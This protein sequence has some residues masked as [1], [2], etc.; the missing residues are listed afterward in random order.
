MK[1]LLA[2]LLAVV[3]TLSL[4]SVMA[5]AEGAQPQ[6]VIDGVKDAAYSD[7]R[8]IDHSYWYTW[9]DASNTTDVVDPDRV[10]N[11][12]WFTWD[13][14]FVYLYFTA[15]G[16]YDLYKPAEGEKKPDRG[17]TFYEQINLY[18]DTAPSAEYLTPCTQGDKNEDGTPADCNHFCCN[19]NAGPGKYNRVMCRYSAA[20][21][22][23]H[24]YYRSD[25]GMFLTFEQFCERRGGESGYEDLEAMYMK[26]NGAGEV[27]GFID[28]ETN[29]YGFEM[30][31]PRNPEEE[32]FQFN[33]VNDVDGYEFEAEGPELPYSLSFCKAP[34]TNSAELLEI[35]F[36]DYEEED[37]PAPVKAII[38]MRSEL[39]ATVE[40]I[41]SEHK[42]AVY[43]LNHEFYQ[44]SDEHKAIALKQTELDGI[45]D[46]LQA[47]VD[48]VNTLAY[49]ANLGD[50]NKD[51]NINANDAL[52][53]LRAAV[54]KVDLDDD[55]IARADVTGDAAVNAKDALEML[56][57]TV[58]KREKFSAAD[59]YEI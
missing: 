36:A 1:K 35:W 44:L 47:A 4:V 14:N 15:V 6:I 12:L 13:D 11:T 16:K 54:G 31:Y 28:Y 2:M 9:A 19:A 57:F 18:L 20:W 25:E 38:R 5:V 37:L 58:G 59:L 8:S 24:N 40:E 29:T 55:S 23:W 33:I 39:P 41:T 3:M 42:D 32:Y 48:R 30:K 45:E 43:K 52:I 17:V 50:V 10:V 53:A 21:D 49:L 22:E 56:Q 46:F 34:W 51:G 26:E 7:F 27:K